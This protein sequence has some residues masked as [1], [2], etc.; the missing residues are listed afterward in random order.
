MR[1]PIVKGFRHEVVSACENPNTSENSP[2]AT[3]N[4]PGR[5]RGLWSAPLQPEQGA[6]GGAESKHEVDEERPSPGR[7][8]GEDAPEE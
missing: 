8:R 2:P 7:V 3:R 1:N 6:D 4:R 5:S